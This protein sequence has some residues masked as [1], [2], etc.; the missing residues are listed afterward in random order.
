MVNKYWVNLILYAIIDRKLPI[1]YNLVKCINAM[2][3]RNDEV[4][5]ASGHLS[6]ME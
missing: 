2:E 3:C 4:G 6:P 1:S 5:F